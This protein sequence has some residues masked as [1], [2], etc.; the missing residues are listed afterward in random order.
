MYARKLVLQGLVCL[1]VGSL[2]GIPI[3]HVRAQQ[4]APAKSQRDLPAVDRKDIEVGTA[5]PDW[6][7]KT[8]GGEFVALSELRGQVVVLDFWA[9]WCGPCR[10]LEPLFDQLVREYQNEPIRFFT[11]SIRPGEDFRA[12]RWWWEDADKKECGLHVHQ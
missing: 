10:K 4:A 8:G 12:G 6:R 2:P 5:A 9:H 3:G 7:L 11:V 1:V